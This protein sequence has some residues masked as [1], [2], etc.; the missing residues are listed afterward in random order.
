[1]ITGA[2]AICES[3]EAT[4]AAINNKIAA[5]ADNRLYNI[6]YELGRIVDYPMFTLLAFYKKVLKDICTDS[7]CDCY[8]TEEDKVKIIERIKIL[9]A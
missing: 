3:C 2:C 7:D 9:T 1:M 4:I 8:G 5:I 6:R